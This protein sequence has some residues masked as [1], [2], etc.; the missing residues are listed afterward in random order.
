MQAAICGL[1]LP[2][3]AGDIILNAGPGGGGK[4]NGLICQRC[5][6]AGQFGKTETGM[7]VRIIIVGE[8]TAMRAVLCADCLTGTARI[9]AT[10]ITA[11]PGDAGIVQR[12]ESR[13]WRWWRWW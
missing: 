9:I 10:G 8:I 2:D 1:H 6:V 7:A 12:R 11:A 13:W 5:S 3:E 4:I